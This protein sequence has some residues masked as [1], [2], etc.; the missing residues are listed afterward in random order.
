MR[1]YVCRGRKREGERRERER[2]GE[3]REREREREREG[4]RERKRGR[5]RVFVCMCEDVWKHVSTHMHKRTHIIYNLKHFNTH[6]H[7][8]AHAHA[9]VHACMQPASLSFS[10][11]LGQLKI[12]Q[13]CPDYFRAIINTPLTADGTAYKC[14]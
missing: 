12:K 1:E 14:Q 5:E 7:T 9:H 2:E 11:S 6:K 10:K 3:R 8:H 13:L 4:E